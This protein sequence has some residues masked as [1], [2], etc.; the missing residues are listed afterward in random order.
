MVFL[1]VATKKLHF[2]PSPNQNLTDSCY[3]FNK[4][5]E[6]CMDLKS[7]RTNLRKSVTPYNENKQSAEI[8]SSLFSRIN[9]SSRSCVSR[10]KHFS[11]TS[12]WKTPCSVFGHKMCSCALSLTKPPCLRKIRAGCVCSVEIFVTFQRYCWL[13]PLAGASYVGSACQSLS[14]NAYIIWKHTQH[15]TQCT[16]P[17]RTW[18]THSIHLSGR[19]LNVNRWRTCVCIYVRKW[20][21]NFPTTRLCSV[22]SPSQHST[23]LRHSRALHN[24]VWCVQLFFYFWCAFLPFH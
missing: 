18:S 21:R 16:E 3:L 8:T 10:A 2:S 15:R 11:R 6:V 22:T 9:Y 7:C 14:Q 5:R 24:L 13:L 17:T 20:G 12:R 19:L 4:R 1:Y 23:V